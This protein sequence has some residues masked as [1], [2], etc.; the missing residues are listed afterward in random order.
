[1]RIGI[2]GATG[3]LGREIVAGLSTEADG[4][5]ETLG[6]DPPTLFATGRSAG[7]TFEWAKDEEL[8]VEAYG[9]ESVR[10]LDVAVV[11]V[12]PEATPGIVQRLRELGV[13]TIDASSTVREAP[14]F[15]EEAARPPK[16]A[17]AAVVTLPS[18]EALAIARVLVGLE[19]FSPRAFKATILKAVSGAGEAGVTDLVEATGR[20]LNGQEPE[21]TALGHRRAFNVIPQAGGFSGA[22]ADTERELALQAQLRSMLADTFS[23]LPTGITTMGW[24]PW[25]YGDFLT[26]NVR[27][28]GEVSLDLIRRA[29]RS[30]PHVK[31]LDDPESAV[32]PTP[33]LATGDDAVLVGRIRTDPT[34]PRGIQLVA[35]IDGARAAASH[36]I[37]A[38]SAVVRARH[39]H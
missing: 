25:L 23:E 8:I 22:A 26:L 1:M 24:G 12:P 16:L 9:T 31:V 17:G 10:G 27:L 30:R 6:T 39:T 32:Y 28:G 21:P 3:L 33:A 38:L 5:A 29:L 18:P 14:L 20:L 4:R 36:A 19:A 13:T 35:A 11:A 37:V 34:E 15:F 2:I 7:E